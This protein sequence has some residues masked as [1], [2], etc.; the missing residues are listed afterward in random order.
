MDIG[1]TTEPIKHAT[2]GGHREGTESIKYAPKYVTE[3]GES[4]EPIKYMTEI[5]H[6]ESK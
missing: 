2:R 3:I 5:S 6:G 4:T 1:E